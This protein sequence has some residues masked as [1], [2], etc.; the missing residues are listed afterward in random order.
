MN[1]LC[2]QKN[3]TK[4]YLSQRTQCECEM[5]I[6]DRHVKKIENNNVENHERTDDRHGLNHCMITNEDTNE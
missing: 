1:W 6:I 5:S 2:Q 4:A 3:E